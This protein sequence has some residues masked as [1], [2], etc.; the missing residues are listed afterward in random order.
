MVGSDGGAARL[1]AEGLCLPNLM[2]SWLA[3]VFWFLWGAFTHWSHSYVKGFGYLASCH[4]APVRM[5]LTVVW[6][7]FAAPGW[8]ALMVGLHVLVPVGRFHLL[9]SSG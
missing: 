8:M 7:T 2:P 9:V 3:S 4:R 5:A 6:L 1:D